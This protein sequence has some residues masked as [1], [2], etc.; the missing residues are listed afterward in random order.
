MPLGMQIGFGSDLIV[1]DGDSAPSVKRGHSPLLFRPCLLW[2]NSWMDQDAT[3]YEGRPRP[4]QHCVWCRPCSTPKGQ[5][6][7]F[8]A[9]VCCGQMAVYR[10]RYL[11]TFL[12]LISGITW[13]NEKV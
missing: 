1:L 9:H 3:W 2:P 5:S 6:P 11:L 10:Y 12:Q 8:S 7:Q 13:Y 4:R